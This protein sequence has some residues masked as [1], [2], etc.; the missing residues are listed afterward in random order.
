LLYFQGEAGV[1]GEARK[2]KI[3]LVKINHSDKELSA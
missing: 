3:F 2:T 1:A